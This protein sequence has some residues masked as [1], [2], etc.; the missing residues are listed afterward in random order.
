MRRASGAQVEFASEKATT[1]LVV[2]ATTA[3]CAAVFPSRG[4]AGDPDAGVAGRQGL[5]RALGPVRGA[6]RGDH[7]LQTVRWVVEGKQVLDPPTDYALLVVRR[8]D[9]GDGR[10]NVVLTDGPGPAAGERSRRE[11]VAHVSPRK[12]ARAQ[13]EQGSDDHGPILDGSSPS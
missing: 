12:R 11:R 13:P 1:S 10:R 9:D 5:D 6:V 8:H 3:S 4:R 2:S 7:N